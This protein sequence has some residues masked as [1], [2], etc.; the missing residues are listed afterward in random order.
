MS[1]PSTKEFKL[2]QDALVRWHDKKLYFCRIVKLP[3]RRDQ[4]VKIEFDDGSFALVARE[5]LHDGI[6]RMAPLI[7]T[8]PIVNAVNAT[9]DD[10]KC[11]V[12]GDDSSAPPNEIIICDQCTSG[13]HQNCVEPPVPASEVGSPNSWLCTD[14]KKGKRDT[15]ASSVICMLTMILSKRS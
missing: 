12:C 7:A 6:L 15:A 2:N 13:Y 10:L 14:C 11:C 3:S 1:S 9:T 5:E 4:R 8:Y